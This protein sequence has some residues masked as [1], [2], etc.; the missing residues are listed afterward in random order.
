MGCTGLHLAARRSRLLSG[1]P[2]LPGHR[3]DR[4]PPRVLAHRAWLSSTARTRAGPGPCFFARACAQVPAR[5]QA[6]STGIPCSAAVRWD[7]QVRLQDSEA[8][9]SLVS[10]WRWSALARNY[11]SSRRLLLPLGDLAGGP[12]FH[13]PGSRLPGLRRPYSSCLLVWT[14]ISLL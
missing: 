5:P 1:R 10:E 9:S 13:D 11:P 4:P 12:L 6:L 2:C 8:S 7:F 14:T 3:A